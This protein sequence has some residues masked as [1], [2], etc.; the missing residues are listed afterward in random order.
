MKN[1]SQRLFSRKNSPLQIFSSYFSQNIQNSLKNTVDNSRSAC[2][3]S[4]KATDKLRGCFKFGSNKNHMNDFII[5]LPVQLSDWLINGRQSHVVL[6][7]Q[8]N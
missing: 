6:L 7:S 2:I 8:M 1:T 4:T 5:D 3:A